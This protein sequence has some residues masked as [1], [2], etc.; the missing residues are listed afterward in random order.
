[1]KQAP[2]QLTIREP[3]RNS[4]RRAWL[5]VCLVALAGLHV[6]AQ[7]GTL[8]APWVSRDIGTVGQP[9]SGSVNSGAFT[10]NGA[11][12]DVGGTADAFHFVYQPLTGDATIVARVAS[13]QG[14]QAWTKVGVMIRA[15]T[16]AGAQ[17]A[18]MLVSTSSGV[19]FQRRVTTGGSTSSTVAAGTAPRWVRLV[20]AGGGI[21]ASVSI[22]GRVWTV[23][24]SATFTMPSTV[25]VGLAASSHDSTRL[26]TGT[27][28][29]VAVSVATP[30]GNGR[31]Q[32]MAG[33]HFLKHEANGAGTTWT[34]SSIAPRRTECT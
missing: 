19:A 25:L 8:A 22:D 30:W 3:V 34:T 24:G 5:F 16:Q 21:T 13:I 33:G 11:G 23:V 2:V 9:G 28:D 17:H 18:F 15:T 20:R 10:V 6:H 31:L 26:A 12:A 32:A 4:S 1:M 7:N 14:G 29:N 27:F